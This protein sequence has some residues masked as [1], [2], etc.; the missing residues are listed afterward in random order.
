MMT[1]LEVDDDDEVSECIR[2]L[3]LSPVLWLLYAF[4]KLIIVQLIKS[5]RLYFQPNLT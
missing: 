5:Y 1:Y 3:N 2:F 4:F